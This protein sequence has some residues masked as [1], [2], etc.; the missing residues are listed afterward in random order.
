MGKGGGGRWNG[1]GWRINE[2]NI[3]KENWS[4]DNLFKKM[5]EIS[6]GKLHFE[7]RV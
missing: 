7:K 3:W 1:M 5:V 2:R 4:L 6:R